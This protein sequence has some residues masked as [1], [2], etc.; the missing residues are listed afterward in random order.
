MLSGSPVILSATKVILSANK[1][2][3]SGT[4]VILSE[5]KDLVQAQDRVSR[6]LKTD[7]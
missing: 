6:E 7:D 5:A 4:N 2:I 3:P 1:V